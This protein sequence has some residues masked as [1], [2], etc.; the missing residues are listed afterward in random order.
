MLGCTIRE[1]N[2]VSVTPSAMAD[3]INPSGLSEATT[4]ALTSCAVVPQRAA[5]NAAKEAYFYVT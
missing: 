1:Q 5:D 4:A 3:A 2:L